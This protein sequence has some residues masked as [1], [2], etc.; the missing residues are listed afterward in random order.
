MMFNDLVAGS[1][2]S[3]RTLKVLVHSNCWLENLRVASQNLFLFLEI[4][5]SN[6]FRRFSA[7]LSLS[8]T[9]QFRELPIPRGAL[10]NKNQ[11]AF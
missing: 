3:R 5:E 2:P 10:Y 6:A 8:E 1:N 7:S 11:K 9:D 4:L